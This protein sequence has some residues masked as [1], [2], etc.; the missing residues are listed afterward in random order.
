MGSAIRT[1]PARL[2]GRWG[3]VQGPALVLTDLAAEG[4]SGG[5]RWCPSSRLL[6]LE[7][8][9]MVAV[10]AEAAPPKRLAHHGREPAPVGIVSGSLCLVFGRGAVLL[11]VVERWLS[12][13]PSSRSNCRT[14]RLV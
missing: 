14:R 6:V 10:A 4:D 7:Q 9:E 11:L 12:P 1:I 2:L 13:E 8:I 3:S 5:L